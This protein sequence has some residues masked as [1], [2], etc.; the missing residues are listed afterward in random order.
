MDNNNMVMDAQLAYE[1]AME[2]LMLM[3]RKVVELT[4]LYKQAL[5]ELNQLK[6]QLEKEE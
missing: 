4:T 2:E 6:Q 5:I 1:T 3:Q